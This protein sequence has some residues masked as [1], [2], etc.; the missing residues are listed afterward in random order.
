VLHRTID[1][2]VSQ[3]E[4]QVKTFENATSLVLAIAAHALVVGVILAL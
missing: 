3:K 1:A 2:A 4:N